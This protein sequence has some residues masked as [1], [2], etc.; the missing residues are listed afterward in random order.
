MTKNIFY[1][2]SWFRIK[3]KA[4]ELS[5]ADIAREKHN[6]EEPYTVLVGSDTQP[7]CFIEIIKHNKMVGVGFLDPLQREYLT[8]QFHL[9]EN[10]N[11]FLTMAVHREFSGDSEHISS[12]TTY[13]FK[14]NGQTLIREERIDPYALS[15][16]E[17]TSDISGHYEQFPDF[18][19]YESLTR[20]ER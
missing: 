10:D 7:E 17:M 12:G 18:G 5:P 19:R 14:E 9:T 13:L 11:L 15:E 3:K 20:L 8:Y 4:L 1:C 6:N 16:S 2:K